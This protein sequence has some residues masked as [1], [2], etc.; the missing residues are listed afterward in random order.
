MVFSQCASQRLPGLF[1]LLAV[2]I[3]QFVGIYAHCIPIGYVLR[4]H[5]CLRVRNGG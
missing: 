1:R 2:P 3:G 5:L 4:W